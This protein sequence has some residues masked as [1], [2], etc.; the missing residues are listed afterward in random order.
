M[1][2]PFRASETIRGGRL[3]SLYRYSALVNGTFAVL[4]VTRPLCGPWSSVEL[5]VDR[6]APLEALPVPQPERASILDAR[7]AALGLLLTEGRRV[8]DQHEAAWPDELEAAVLGYLDQIG[9]GIT[10]A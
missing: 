5:Q 8:A 2:C 3:S 10:L 1:G 4:L 6:P 7:Q 9:Y